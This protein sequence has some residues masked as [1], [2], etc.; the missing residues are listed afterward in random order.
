MY[1]LQRCQLR[2]V[3]SQAKRG[4]G[5]SDCGTV[6]A[7]FKKNEKKLIV[8]LTVSDESIKLFFCNI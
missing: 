2:T 6:E 4:G 1:D 3:R 5:L 8:I 7:V